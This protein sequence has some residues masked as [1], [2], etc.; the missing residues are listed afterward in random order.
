M[1]SELDVIRHAIL[2]EDEGAAFYYMAAA[3]TDDETLK[4]AYTHLKDEELKHGK[5]LRSLYERMVQQETTAEFE[6]K[7]LEEVKGQ[8]PRLFAQAASKFKMAITDMAVFAAGALME[9]ASIE[10]YKKAS[11]Q[12]KS[13][14][15]KQLYEILIKWEDDH[16]HQLKTIHEALMKDW[17]DQYEYTHSPKL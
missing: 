15:A 2:N 10:F 5:W 12:T 4:E 16:L 7:P 6:W 14:E 9:E 13:A 1:T 11:A 3:K 8:S 17:L